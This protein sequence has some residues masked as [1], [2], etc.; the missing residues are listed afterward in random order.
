MVGAEAKLLRGGEPSFLYQKVSTFLI[1]DNEGEQ[2]EVS[3]FLTRAAPK[4]E[5]EQDNQAV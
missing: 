5:W 1:R 2:M 4:R 3:F